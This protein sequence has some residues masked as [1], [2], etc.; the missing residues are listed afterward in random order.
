VIAGEADATLTVGAAPGCRLLPIQ[1]ESQGPSLLLNDSKLLD[2]LN[3]L[4]DKVDIVSN[5]WGRVPSNLRAQMVV[6]RLTELAR[7]GGRRGRGIVFLWA[8]G[9]ENCPI[10]HD[11]TV[12][13][14]FTNGWAPDGSLFWVGVQTARQFRNNFVGIPGVAHIAALSSFGQRSHY[15]N[16]GTGID[17]CAPTSNSHEY[18]RLG[19]VGLRV[20][21]TTGTSAL[22]TPGFGGTSSATPLVAGIAGLVIS[23]N[24]DLSALDVISVLK[25]TASK[26]LNMDGY[27]KTPA[28]AFDSDTSWD[29]SP[30]APFS[31]GAFQTNNNDPNGTW[32]P[33]FGHGR[34]DA[35]AAVAEAIRRRGSTNPQQQTFRRASSPALQIPDN[36]NAGLRNTIQFT[37]SALLSSIKVSVDISHTFIGDLRLTLIAPSGT[38]VI[39]HDRRGG[40]ADNIRSIF[41]ITN[42]PGLSALTGQ[43]IQGA[44]TL[45]IQDLA[46][47][48]IGTLNRWEIEIAGQQAS[49]VELSESPGTTIP[50]NNPAG[51]ERTL[52]TNETGRVREVAVSVD[53]T[54]TFIGDLAVTLVSPT[55][56]SVPLH[57]NTGGNTDNLITTYNATNAEALRNLQ[58]E[59]ITGA[60]KL[61][62]ADT[63]ALDIGK[64]NRWSLRISRA[65]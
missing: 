38:A 42:T 2:A 55:G 52:T 48:D 16:Y 15:S 65:S 13:V 19:V 49:I 61:K 63:A 26:D 4:A 32:S 62:V 1:W 34:V 3:F 45:H 46:A 23:A 57:R 25:Q 41:D 14:P 24:P 27:S 40:N 6:N 58:G 51:I 17:V 12:N 9:N 20:T 56:T 33:W 21:T 28:A 31:G 60:W 8:A 11:A 47:Q 50:D 64:L 59:S 53:I 36:N 29:V 7:T 35:P 37:E 10:Q 54:H 22:V 44:W 18:R 43:Q 5:S 39:L 30:I